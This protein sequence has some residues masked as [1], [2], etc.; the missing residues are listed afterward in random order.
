MALDIEKF[1]QLQSEEKKSVGL[2]ATE[3]LARKVAQPPQK[4]SFLER[5]KTSLGERA[6]MIKETFQ[7]TARGEISPLE[8]GVRFVGDVAGGVGDVAGAALSPAI[9]KIAQTDIGREVFDVLGKGMDRYEEWKNTSEVNRRVGE[10]VEGVVNIADLAG[11]AKLGTSA[12]KIGANVVSDTVSKVKDLASSA[13]KRV[14]SV[15]AGAEEVGKS[16]SETVVK[17]ATG[18]DP[19]TIRLAV[20]QGE[21]LTQAQAD[22]LTRMSLANQFEETLSARI[23][24]LS[25][26]GKEYEPIR[27]SGAVVSVTP[28]GY[29]DLLKE[30]FNLDV[31]KTDSGF[32]VKRTTKSKPLSESDRKS[33]EDFLDLYADKS[34]LDAEEF[35]T[36]RGAL[37]DI[38]RWDQG[39]TTFSKQIAKDLRRFHDS[40]SNQ[41]SGLKELD[42]QYAPEA[43]I[44][45]E[46]RKEFIDQN[47]GELKDSA[48]SKLANI[49]S[50]TNAKR[51]ERLKQIDPEI[52]QKASVL[53]AIED[54]EY[55]GKQTVGAYGRAA[56][57]GG[58]IVTGNP[59]LIVAAL[60]TASPTLMINT[61]RQVGNVIGIPQS[62]LSSIQSKLK[63]GVKLNAKEA[64][65]FKKIAE[66]IKE[67][68][69]EATGAVTV[70][71][72]TDAIE[73]EMD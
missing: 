55:A 3:A 52:E 20:T 19:D 14:S 17:T 51:L 46:I 43:K 25:G 36:A 5:V 26:I 32:N 56:V 50:P 54:I 6:G 68:V 73:E 29:V 57:L 28:N 10:L 42:A 53:K 39:K 59:V 31:Q 40:F 63:T 2:S 65:A 70:S 64:S 62:L 22:G 1:K 58:S 11:G 27:K 60:L 13:K 71:G 41:I 72:V 37:D 69:T 16:L 33:I 34:Q 30:K 12:A 21:K 67:N 15:A 47:T 9:E 18:L 45:S 49:N 23:N 48:L 24:Q 38:A 61:L 7:E 44:L 66:Q 35:L 4:Q 8:T